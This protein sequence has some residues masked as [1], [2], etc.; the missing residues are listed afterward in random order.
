[1]EACAV[2]PRPDQDGTWIMPEM[3]E[4]YVRL[5]E[6]GAAHSVEVW[7]E[8]HELVG[9]LYGVEL[10]RIFFGESMFHRRPDASKL[11]LVR[12]MEKLASHGC[13]LVDC[14]MKTSHIMRY[15]AECI[16]RQDFLRQL[17]NEFSGKKELVVGKW[18]EP[19][20]SS[21]K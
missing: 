14:Q 10:G 3:V 18:D 8:G 15:G 17:G 5:H 7:G 9:G 21:G 16:P 19:A 20:D 6:L 13:R 4:A 1:M 11:A 12:L 2:T